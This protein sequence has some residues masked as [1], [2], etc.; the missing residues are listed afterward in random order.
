VCAG[1]VEI[2]MDVHDPASALTKLEAIAK[3]LGI[4]DRTRIDER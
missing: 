1:I 3:R 2:H 4:H